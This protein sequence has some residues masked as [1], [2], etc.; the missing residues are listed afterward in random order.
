MERNIMIRR[1]FN[2]VLVYICIIVGLVGI[3]WA[4][5]GIF[6]NIRS[7][8]T[9]T[10]NN[11]RSTGT[12]TVS[13]I[14]GTTGTITSLSST[15]AIISSITASTISVGDINSSGTATFN[16]L[17]V[18]GGGLSSHLTNT[19]NPHATSDANLITSNIVTNNTS[20]TKH[21]FCPAL[22]G[23]IGQCLNGIGVFSNVVSIGTTS[24]V[25]S[26]RDIGTIYTNST[27]KTMFVLASFNTGTLANSIGI[28]TGVE[29]AD[30]AVGMLSSF[31]TITTGAVKPIMF[32]VPPG[33]K[34]KASYVSGSGATVTKWVEWY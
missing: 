24:Q 31:A 13:T 18:N 34:Y 2:A 32:I 20:T 1:F 23:D 15:T 11:I 21:G 3:S 30:V 5:D 22:S 25:T 26:S 29:T 14:S 17:V 12:A 9:V 16:N 10:V 4:V 19:S 7:S 6:T 33:Y 27:G 8:G 28:Y